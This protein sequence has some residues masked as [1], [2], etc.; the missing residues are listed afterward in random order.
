MTAVHNWL[1]LSKYKLTWL[2]LEYENNQAD[3]NGLRVQETQFTS[4]ILPANWKE[5]ILVFTHTH[6][7]VIFLQKNQLAS[8]KPLLHFVFLLH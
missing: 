7:V 5:G 2:I 6:V 8:V 3:E 1:F 4:D